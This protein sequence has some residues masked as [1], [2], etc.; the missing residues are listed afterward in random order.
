VNRQNQDWSWATPSIKIYQYIQ[1]IHLLAWLDMLLIEDIYIVF[2]CS[3]EP[4]SQLSFSDRNVSGVH[5]SVCHKL[6]IFSTSFSEPLHA[7]S[8]NL[9][10][11]LLY[12]LWWSVLS[13]WSNYRS[14]MATWS[15]VGYS[16]LLH[17][18]W[19]D[20]PEMFLWCSTKSVVTF[21]NDS[22]ARMATPASYWLWPF[23]KKIPQTYSYKVTSLSEIL[24][25]GYLRIVHTPWSGSKSK[26]A[27]L[28]S[29]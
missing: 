21:Q 5:T 29:I 25:L 20:L 16:E 17:M 7:K 15:L 12:G 9:P 28:A 13:F 10:Q 18:K 6:F 4:E 1:L 24:H 26:M 14:K 8:P 19:P 22:I 23:L 3:P 2:S 27:V 11:M